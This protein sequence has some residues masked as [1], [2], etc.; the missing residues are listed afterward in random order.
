MWAEHEVVRLDDSEALQRRLDPRRV[1]AVSRPV[2][3]V[4]PADEVAITSYVA[5]RIEMRVNLSSPGLVVLSELD[6]P[7]WKVKVDGRA[8]PVVRADGALRAVAA[9]AGEHTMVWYYRR[10]RRRS[11]SSSAASRLSSYC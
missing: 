4:A 10:R 11:A 9:P 2:N 3:V 6:Y 5:D 1:A 7:A 8:Q